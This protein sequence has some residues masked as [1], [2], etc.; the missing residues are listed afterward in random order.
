V[1]PLTEAQ[2]ATLRRR[3]GNAPD[4][5]GLQAVYDRTESLTETVREI[6]EIRLANLLADPASYS[7]AGEYSQ[8][9]SANIK[10]IESA[11]AWLGNL[12]DD[13]P[14]DDSVVEDELAILNPAPPPFIR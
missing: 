3:V 14:I 11:L 2:L 9:T 4:D 8:D 7:I 5:A 6:L 1:E 12:D 10:A 13:D